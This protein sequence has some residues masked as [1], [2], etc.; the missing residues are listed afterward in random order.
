VDG[1]RSQELLKRA[2]G[3]D[4]HFA[5]AHQWLGVI[6]ETTILA[7]ESNDRSLLYKADEEIRLA[8]QEDPSLA[9]VHAELAGVAFMLG[10]KQRA[11]AEVNQSLTQDPLSQQGR[12]W[13]LNLH[14]MT[15][16]NSA[17]KD[18]ALS[19]LDRDPL[20]AP[21]RII[22]SQILV[23]EGNFA[24][25]LREARTLVDQAPD[26]S[27]A[28]HSLSSVYMATG[29]L[30]KARKLLDEK[31]AVLGSNYIWSLTWAQL[32]AQENKREE[33]LRAMDPETLKWADV[34]FVQTLHVAEFYAVLGDGPKAIDWLGRAVR[35][36]DER[37]EWFRKNPRLASIRID[38]NFQRIIDS[39]ESRRKQR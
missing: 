32:L 30:D 37:V 24:G 31:R 18:L 29:E 26:G 39:I 4:P 17:A 34:N 19:I 1:A 16:E 27:G 21:A 8:A 33:A 22:L 12:A 10:D 28:F 15:G 36:G 2:I 13:R 9:G 14:Y 11:L 35:N 23:T 20:H 25:A 7:G 6:Y 5:A 38:P 3:L